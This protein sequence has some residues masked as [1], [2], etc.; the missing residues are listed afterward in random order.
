[1]DTRAKIKV[2]QAFEENC[3]AGPLAKEPMARMIIKLEDCKLHEDSIHRGPA[4][5][6][7]AMRQA[8]LGAML[9]GGAMLYEPMQTI[10]IDAPVEYLGAISKLIQGRRGQL[11]DTSQETGLVVKC[12]LPVAEMFGF[13][14]SLRSATSGHGAWFLVDQSFEKLPENLQNQIVMRVRERKG[15]KKEI[16]KYEE[17]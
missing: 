13:T 17:E 12:K 4:Q 14:S 11:L 6:I 3:N 10:R 5:I 16:P 1:M 7:P 9:R 8:I 2:M 15:M